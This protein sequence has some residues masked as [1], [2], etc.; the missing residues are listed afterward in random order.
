MCALRGLWLGSPESGAQPVNGNQ[1][2]LNM[3]SSEVRTALRGERSRY[4]YPFFINEEVEPQSIPCRAGAEGEQELRSL[5]GASPR[6]LAF[7]TGVT[8]LVSA[9]ICVCV[10]VCV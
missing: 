3:I 4:R 6:T 7:P 1:A 9:Q 2:L 10:C 5:L 8:R